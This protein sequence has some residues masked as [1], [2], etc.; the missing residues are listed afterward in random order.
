MVDYYNNLYLDL[1]NAR[2]RKDF[3][4]RL[5]DESHF[6]KAQR[7]VVQTRLNNLMNQNFSEVYNSEGLSTKA[8]LIRGGPG[9]GKTLL[10]IKCL[11][12]IQDAGFSVKLLTFYDSLDKYIKYLFSFYN[13]SYLF[14]NNTESK[15]DEVAIDILKNNGISSVRDF[16][17]KKLSLV[18]G[19]EIQDNQE[20]I[21]EIFKQNLGDKGSLIFRLAEEQIWPNL[22]S[23]E[24]FLDWS[25]KNGRWHD[26]YCDKQAFSQEHTEENFKLYL[27]VHQQLIKQKSLYYNFS[28]YYLKYD[29]PQAAKASL[30]NESL[31]YILV[32]E[33]QDLTFAQLY[34]IAQLTKNACILAGDID[35]SIRHRITWSH[36]GLDVRGS[37]I[38]LD[39]NCRST[40]QIQNLVQKYH[41]HLVIREE[42]NITTSYLEGPPPELYLVDDNEVT[43]ENTY[44]T[45]CRSVKVLIEDMN[46]MPENICVVTFNELHLKNIHK[47]LVKKG[48]PSKLIYKSDILDIDELQN[49]T[50]ESCIKLS[51]VKRIKGIDCPVLLFMIPDLSVKENRDE[52]DEI[53][54]PNSIYT[55]IGRAVYLLQVFI[56]KF[57]VDKDDNIKNLVYE[58]DYQ[59]QSISGFDV[60]QSQEYDYQRVIKYVSSN[61]E[62]FN[63]IDKISWFLQNK[64]GMESSNCI[65]LARVIYRKVYSTGEKSQEESSIEDLDG[66]QKQEIM[67]SNSVMVKAKKDLKLKSKKIR[68]IAIKK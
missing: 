58:M 64:Y 16:I 62:E 14:S 25:W 50:D 45:I 60:S 55:C 27:Q 37:S 32:D 67:E 57:C 66:E 53:N 5:L 9:T 18:F 31:N 44:T 29:F 41:K 22:C 42:E 2:T 56:P 68:V 23:E 34:V 4:Q 10:L 33:A 19:K 8:L 51:T 12:K 38:K 40:M 43:Y 15:I 39:C 11:K 61:I 17:N 63:S 28:Y 48:I 6:T 36:V 59:Q 13:E 49:Y 21:K 24:N 3:E 20:P 65:A 1:L 52:I 26:Y 30:L 35:Q 7:E 47:S 54:I 46:V